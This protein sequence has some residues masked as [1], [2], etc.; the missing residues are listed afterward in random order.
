M[1]ETLS[2]GSFHI[3]ESLLPTG[4]AE[5]YIVDLAKSMIHSGIP[6]HLGTGRV[7]E[8]A[9]PRISHII[10]GIDE[11]TEGEPLLR[12]VGEV[13]VVME[14]NE[15]EVVHLHSIDNPGLYNQLAESFPIIR[16]VHDSRAVCPT[17]FRINGTGQLCGVAI[18][19]QC[20]NCPADGLEMAIIADKK[21]TLNA[22]N[23]LDLVLVP[24][25]YTKEQLVINGV[26]KE[27]VEVL[28][29]FVPTGLE[30][31]PK[32][33]ESHASD[34]LFIGRVV[35]SK[36]LAEAIEAVSRIKQSFRFVVCGDGPDIGT[37][38]KM[39]IDFEM[40]DKV[41]FVGW[42]DRK[43]TG[44]YLAGTGVLVVPSIGPE[45]FGLV[46]LEAMYYRKPVVAFNAGG[47][48]EWLRSGENG[49]L[50]ERGN[51]DEMTRALSI[52]LSSKK[53]RTD[54][55]N[56]GKAMADTEF[57]IESHK[58]KLMGVYSRIKR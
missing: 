36:G 9:L 16:T 15:L 1:P 45:S 3:N 12:Q 40:T 4:G 38:Q 2:V 30:P 13:V 41:K 47:I 58:Q 42:T 34:I 52:L 43:E 56:Q 28:P 57:T 7:E 31:K 33:V 24:S 5:G 25:E 39:V 26:S 17:E 20:L 48:N 21:K 37:C 23:K 22:L 50:V 46:G 55:G 27:K 54:F 8:L 51:I 29:L 49:F 19:D 35:K 6:I 11:K 44:K 18:G 53:T 14:K 32:D 10:P